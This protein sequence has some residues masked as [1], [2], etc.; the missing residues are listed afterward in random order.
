V[1]NVLQLLVLF[2]ER[3]SC[4]NLVLYVLGVCDSKYNVKDFHFGFHWEM[5][6]DRQN[7]YSK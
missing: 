1:V 5:T 2:Q 6:S 3:F 7:S 4:S